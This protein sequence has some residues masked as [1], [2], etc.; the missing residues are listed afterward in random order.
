M[1]ITSATTAIISVRAMANLMRIPVER[2]SCIG[3]FLIKT[4][5]RLLLPREDSGESQ[6]LPESFSLA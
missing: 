3:C 2:V 5:T 4:A 6:N 1:G